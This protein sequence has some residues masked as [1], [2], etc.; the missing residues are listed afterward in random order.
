MKHHFCIL[1]V[2]YFLHGLCRYVYC[3]FCLVETSYSEHVAEVFNITCAYG[4]LAVYPHLPELKRTAVE[5]G[6][7]GH[8][9]LALL[10]PV[11]YPYATAYRHIAV[12]NNACA[13]VFG[14]YNDGLI[15]AVCAFRQTYGYVLC[16]VHAS[17]FSGLLQG[18][19]Y[20]V[21]ARLDNQ[22]GRIDAYSG[23][24]CGY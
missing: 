18:F 8:V 19:L 10:V 17:F 16:V 20:S 2:H 1:G 13:V 14:S 24:S 9:H 3:F 22:V 11:G 7:V 23:K 6:H 12:G 5:V 21:C 15:K 4:F